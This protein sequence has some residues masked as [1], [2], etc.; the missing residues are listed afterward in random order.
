MVGLAPVPGRRSGIIVWGDQRGA[1][2]A[3]YDG[4]GRLDLVVTQNGSE[5]KLFHNR[6]AAPG[7]RVRLQGPAGNPDGIG[8]LDYCEL[9]VEKTLESGDPETLGG[10][11]IF[12]VRIENTGTLPLFNVGLAD[13]FDDFFLEFEEASHEPDFGPE[14]GVV[15]FEPLDES[16]GSGVWEPGDFLVVTVTFEA[17]EVTDDGDAENCAL[18]FANPFLKTAAAPGATVQQLPELSSEEDCAD[19]QIVEDEPE[20]TD[21]PPELPTPT[22]EPELTEPTPV[23]TAVPPTPTPP[24]GDVDPDTISPPDTGSGPDG[25][26]GAGTWLLA[27]LAGAAILASAAGLYVGKRNT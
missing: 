15:V 7:L 18:A 20:D 3:D 12:E 21:R 17:I 11:V 13:F 5:T 8:G 10:H 4:D 9:T 16:G 26:A 27:A 6:G 23:A 19:V 24:S 25:G 14:D 1:A 2:H 22:V